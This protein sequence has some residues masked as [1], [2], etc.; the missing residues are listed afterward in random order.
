MR[1]QLYDVTESMH[2]WIDDDGTTKSVTAKFEKGQVLESDAPNIKNTDG[3]PVKVGDFERW[4]KRLVKV[5]SAREV[6]TGDPLMTIEQLNER[7]A[8]IADAHVP[9]E[10]AAK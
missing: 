7:L 1:I 8:A 3:K 10:E 6:G 2:Q 9:D 5:S 4:L